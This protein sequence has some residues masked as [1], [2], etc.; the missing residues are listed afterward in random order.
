MVQWV[1][2]PMFSCSSLVQSLV[3]KQT[4]KKDAIGDCD[5]KT[6]TER[7]EEDKIEPASEISHLKFSCEEGRQRSS[8]DERVFS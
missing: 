8:T 1:K 6:F 5:K 3:K 4:K 2:D 7:V